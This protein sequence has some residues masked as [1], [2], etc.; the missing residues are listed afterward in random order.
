MSRRVKVICNFFIKQS[1]LKRAVFL[2]LLLIAF[3]GIF[4]SRDNSVGYYFLKDMAEENILDLKLHYTHSQVHTAFESLGELGRNAYSRNL[5]VLDIFYPLLMGLV[6]ANFI[7]FLLKHLKQQK[8]FLQFSILLPLCFFSLDIL[9]NIQIYSLLKSYP[10]LRED[11]VG[12]ASL[13]THLKW[14][15]IYSSQILILTGI[16]AVLGRWIWKKI[17]PNTPNTVSESS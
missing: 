1:S 9:E 4:Y 11:A 16:V 12:A 10:H 13:T 15:S 6:F 7:G 17:K 2:L 8:T 5:M 14:M 3:S